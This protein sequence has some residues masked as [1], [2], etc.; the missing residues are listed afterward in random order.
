MN[1]SNALE[2]VDLTVRYPRMD[3]PALSSVSMVVP[4]GSF[5]AVL[6]PNGSG[7]STLLRALL[8]MVPSVT[9]ETRVSGRGVSE[10]NRRAL[11]REVGVVPQAESVAFPLTVRANPP[12]G[13]RSSGGLAQTARTSFMMTSPCWSRRV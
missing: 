2:A 7:K 4:R 6:G 5:Y 13:K 9:G 3:H 8:G 11:A 12:A 1:D 10:W